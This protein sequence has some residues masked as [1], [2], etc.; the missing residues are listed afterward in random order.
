MP[1]SSRIRHELRAILVLALPLV[2]GQL[3]A[4]GLNVV[5]TLLAG[6]MGGGTLAA[7]GLGAA[8][9]SVVIL[10]A[11]GLMLAV[12]PSVAQLVGAGRQ[13]DI[14]PLFRQ[15]L[16]LAL[17]VGIGMMAAIRAAPWL[18]AQ[19]GSDR[20]IIPET[21]SFLTPLAWGAPAQFL[22]FFARGLSEGLGLTRPTLWFSA[23]GVLLLAPLGYALMTGIAGLPGLG[24]FGLGL[25]YAITLWV[26]AISLLIYLAR[27]RNYRHLH[28]F[29]LFEWPRWRPVAALLSV[30]LPMGVAVW[31]EGGLFV[32][33]AMLMSRFGETAMAAHPVAINV[34]SVAFMVPM[35]IALAITIRV[36]QAVGRDD[37][38]GVR[39]AGFTG[40]G[41]VLLTQIVLASV[42]ALAAGPIAALYTDDH[43]VI[44]AAAHLLLFA[45][46]FQLSDGVQV[47]SN[48]ALRG[49]KDTI[50]PAVIT[51]TS[52]WVVGMSLGGW[53][54]FRRGFGPDG[55]WLGLIAGLT[56]A[57]IG[58]FSRFAWRAWRAN[59]PRLRQDASV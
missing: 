57:A 58:L 36:G 4:V 33:T 42:L 10:V 14:A 37:V 40:I 55:L 47:A 44:A 21:V 3:C 54:A 34:A 29:A 43:A 7:V 41:L 19:V 38:D 27:H 32:A 22:F 18:L 31:M 52:Y 50:V 23:L 2:A 16:W 35:G 46:V 26:Q 6:H 56:A 11:L 1:D 13:Q 45:A 49:L 9:W 24:A 12:P 15:A 30:A 48:G 17:I 51:A 28:L 39:H 8:I 20:S 59:W 53:L 25:A 5:E